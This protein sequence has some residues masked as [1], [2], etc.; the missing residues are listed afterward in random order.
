MA[1]DILGENLSNELRKAM[2]AAVKCTLELENLPSAEVSVRVMTDEEIRNLNRDFRDKDRATDVLSF[3]EYDL[4]EP[5]AQAISK[6]Q[7]EKKNLFLG[8][9]AVSIE[10]AKRQ[11]KENANTLMEEM[12]F[13]C[14]HGTLHLLGYDHMDQSGEEVMRDKQRKAKHKLQKDCLVGI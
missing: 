5:I 3:P 2:K 13:L 4:K 10:T 8:D 1:V 14:I 9:I 7:I 6:G 12:C 11:A